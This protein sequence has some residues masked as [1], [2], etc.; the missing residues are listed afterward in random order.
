VPKIL[1]ADDDDAITLVLSTLLEEGG[2]LV[3][4]ASSAAD[5][6][7]YLKAYSYDMIILDWQ[8]PDGSGIDIITEFRNSGGLTPILMLT[9]KDS[10]D[11]KERGLEAGA[12]DYLTKPFHER[13]LKA[14]MKALLR[15]P[16]LIVTERLQ[17]S[18]LVM[19]RQSRRLWLADKEIPLQPIEFDLIEFFMLNPNTVFS[20][21]EILQRV[22]DS[23]CEVS[24][25]AIYSCIKR[26]RKK[27]D[28]PGRSSMLRNV[29]GVGYQLMSS[30]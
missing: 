22:W 12:D 21:T 14:R 27:L 29:H 20:A 7:A 30:E 5:T 26:L 18:N 8:F 15:R 4:I 24:F 25:D 3:D 16:A 23:G 10:I 6:S 2:S 19:D 13:E 1:I 9:G 11:D 17:F 28:L